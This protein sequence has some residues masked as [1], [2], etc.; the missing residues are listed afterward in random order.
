MILFL[1]KYNRTFVNL[2]FKLYNKVGRPIRTK[3]QV[4]K[5]RYYVQKAKVT[6][7]IVQIGL[8]NGFYCSPT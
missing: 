5:Y 8:V 1:F 7:T 6:L 4:E 2:F 3:R